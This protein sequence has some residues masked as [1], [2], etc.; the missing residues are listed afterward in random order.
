MKNKRRRLSSWENMNDNK[1][2][3]NYKNGRYLDNRGQKLLTNILRLE[4]NSSGN[5]R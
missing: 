4:G 1:F 2:R 3:K 5:E